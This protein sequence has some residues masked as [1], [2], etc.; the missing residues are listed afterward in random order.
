[1]RSLPSPSKPVSGEPS[2]FSRI[3]AKSA[4]A[5]FQDVPAMRIR[6]SG[7]TVRLRPRS[8]PL[9][10]GTRTVPSPSKVVSGEPSAFS[11]SRLKS[12]SLPFQDVPATRIRPSGSTVTVWGEAL[13]VPT[14]ATSVPV[15]AGGAKV[16][17]SLTGVT[18]ID[19]VSA[20]ALKPSAPLPG[21]GTSWYSPS[22]DAS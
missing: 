20:S 21:E 10:A 16:G 12:S 4:S 7:S 19:A 3:T 11:R 14:G 6:P 5:P 13:P 22:S 15:P 17:A 2:A 8:L 1:M 18:V 9:P